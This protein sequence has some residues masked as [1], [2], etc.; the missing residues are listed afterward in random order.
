[1]ERAR[2]FDELRSEWSALAE[3][4]SSIFAT[5]EWSDVWWRHFGGGQKLLL[6]ACRS[7]DGRLVSVLPLY[8]WRARRPRVIR[9]LG[10]GPGDELGPVHALGAE[11][12]AARGL[13]VV[14]DML[15]WDVFFGEQLPVEERWSALLGASTWRWEASPILRIPRGGWDEYLASRSSNFRQQLARRRR[16]L[17]GTGA[18]GFRLADET[19]LDRDLDTLF[20]LH[21]V[22]WGSRQTDF[23]DTRF[24][25][26]LAHTALERGWLRLWL[27]ELDGRPVAAWHGFQVG[28]VT[29]YYQA[30]RDPAYERFSVGFVLLA[31]TL[32]AAIEEGATEYRFG[33]GAEGFK[34]RFT[35]E[36]PGLETVALPRGPV[37][38]AALGFGRTVQYMHRLRRAR[39]GS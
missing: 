11:D 13:R 19:S 10:H 21:R 28:E 16:A 37:G 36:D 38:R 26:E 15:R 14:L 9:F 7:A 32:R 34:Y 22:R 23:A 27:L 3:S 35:R 17:E 39:S 6:H 1:M 30:G 33:R 4:R 18:V 31:H 25:R 2:S 5:W 24:H 8:L 20:A 12:V 29:S